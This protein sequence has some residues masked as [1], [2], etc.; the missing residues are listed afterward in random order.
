M[1]KPDEVQISTSPACLTLPQ[2]F[3]LQRVASQLPK[4][5]SAE[6]E[7]DIAFGFSERHFFK[8]TGVF[9]F[10]DFEM[11]WSTKSNSYSSCNSFIFDLWPKVW[12]LPFKPIKSVVPWPASWEGMTEWSLF[13]WKAEA[14]LKTLRWACHARL[15]PSLRPYRSTEDFSIPA[16]SLGPEHFVLCLCL[17]LLVDC[18]GSHSSP[19]KT[20]LFQGAPSYHWFLLGRAL[21]GTGSSAIAIILAISR[22]CYENEEERLKAGAMEQI[23]GRSPVDARSVVCCLA[24]CCWGHLSPHRLEGSWLPGLSP[25]LLSQHIHIGSAHFCHLFLQVWLEIQLF[26]ARWCVQQHLL[27]QLPFGARDFSQSAE[28]IVSPCCLEDRFTQIQH[29]CQHVLIGKKYEQ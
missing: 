2:N 19:E 26:Y 1:L 3:R 27:L 16:A 8:G 29:K 24:P 23:S 11:V 22:D 5:K 15:R 21:Q 4:L 10:V 14:V 12:A 13:R 7:V 28:V 17:G 18:F 9:C 6:I 20:P 25:L